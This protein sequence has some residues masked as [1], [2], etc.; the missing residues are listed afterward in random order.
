MPS[1]PC[2]VRQAE[3]DPPGTAFFSQTADAARVE[4]S[5][6]L[7]AA[8]VATT[9]EAIISFAAAGGAI[10]TWNKGAERLFGYTEAEAVGGPV[11]LLVPSS[12][13]DGDATGVYSLAMAGHTVRDHKTVRVS[14]A[15]ELIPVTV[16]A[17]RMLGANGR[18]IGVSA[19]FR[20]LRPQ[21]RVETALRESEAKLRALNQ[22]LEARVQAEIV[23]REAAQLRA[24]HAERMHALGQL[25]GGIAHDFNNI[26]QVTQNA[27]GLIERRAADPATVGRFARVILDVTDRGISITRRLLSFAR[28]GELRAEPIEPARLLSGLREVLRHTLGSTIAV[29]VEAPTEQLLL[30]DK[31]QLETVLVNLAT[32]A[33]D[34]MPDGGRLALAA[35]TEAVLD[36]GVHPAALNPG[37]YVRLSISDTG[38]GMEPTVLARAIEPFFTTKPQGKGTGLGLSMAKGFAEQSGGGLLIDS[39]L[40]RGTAVHLWLPATDR[41]SRSAADGG[42]GKPGTRGRGRCI[43]LVDDEAM[44]R[45][46]LTEIL[47]EDGYAVVSAADGAEALNVLA[48]AKRI[49]ALVTDLTMPGI[50]GLAVIRQARASRPG[51]PGILLTGHADESIQHAAN[52]A[53]SGVFTLLRKPVPA[54]QLLDRI[55]VLLR[56]A[57]QAGRGPAE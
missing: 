41:E 55:D 53:T 1:E 3:T 14:K 5:N 7:L 49:D 20:D 4:K 37:R 21:Q 10:Q 23:A 9:D 29:R 15:G 52:D 51:L 57:A 27:A 28:R 35:E 26:L 31:G 30:A 8:I 54:A 25:A 46:T 42:H 16:T 24:G 11:G 56:P 2:Q 39:A 18:V 47:E 32:N 22:E 45:E 40:G 19:I 48:S 38:Q 6:A 50:N 33:R 17:T 44:I 34:A 13:P 12:L 36:P 43:L